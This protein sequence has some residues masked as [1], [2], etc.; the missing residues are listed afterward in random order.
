MLVQLCV[1]SLSL[2]LGLEVVQLYS[3]VTLGSYQQ[4]LQDKFSLFDAHFK[5]GLFLSPYYFLPLI[6]WVGSIF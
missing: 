6:S 5:D 2:G 1:L 3:L 4:R